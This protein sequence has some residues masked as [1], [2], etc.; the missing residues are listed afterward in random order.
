MKYFL[1]SIFLFGLVGCSDAGDF[2]V[3][4][5]YKAK[6]YV[7]E[8]GGS[9]NEPTI[10]TK[11]VGSSGEGYSKRIYNCAQNTVKY[12]GSGSTLREMK[13]SK[14]DVKMSPVIYKSIAYYVGQQVC[15]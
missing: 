9:R 2:P 7:I 3:P 6:Y 4:S 13:I 15:K 12:L 11:R 10:T 8:K 5:D 14:S 1:L